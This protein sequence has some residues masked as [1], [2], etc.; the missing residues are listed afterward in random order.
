MKAQQATEVF[1]A[2]LTSLQS[3][4]PVVFVCRNNGSAISTPTSEQYRGDGIASRGVGCGI[5]TMRV[6]GTDIFATYETTVEP[7]RRVLEGSK[8]ILLK[9][10]SH[11]SGHH[12]TSDDSFV[13]RSDRDAA[14]WS[15]QHSAVSLLR[16]WLQKR[17]LWSA[18]L[19]KHTGSRIRKDII[20]AMKT[21]EKELMPP[22]SSIWDDV[23]TEYSDE[24]MAQRAEF[25][26]LVDEYPGEYDVED[27]EGG[28]ASL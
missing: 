28:A 27:Y 24:Q 5:E 8:P 19:D 25:R 23:Y 3:E 4:C 17:K 21:A 10:M 14:D 2:L 20:S 26:R 9:L 11:R 13:Y 7:R 18:E 16:R 15:T 12:S 22:L 1:T 6:D